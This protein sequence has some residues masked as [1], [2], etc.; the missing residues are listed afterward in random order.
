[1]P[2]L[3]TT[4]NTWRLSIP[5]HEPVPCHRVNFGVGYH[6]QDWQIY[7]MTLL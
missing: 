2:L 7:V 5:I 6:L 3:L 1:M 4:I